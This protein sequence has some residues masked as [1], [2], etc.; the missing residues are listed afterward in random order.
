MW[1]LPCS[2]SDGGGWVTRSIEPPEQ[3]SRKP[4]RFLEDRSPKPFWLMLQ[5]IFS[6]ECEINIGAR[7]SSLKLHKKVTSMPQIRFRIVG[8]DFLERRWASYVGNVNLEDP[9]ST[10]SKLWHWK[11]YKQQNRALLYTNPNYFSVTKIHD[12]TAV[13]WD[14]RSQDSS[15]SFRRKWETC[16]F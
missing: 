6:I 7:N 9:G 12:H 1:K 15:V 11:S 3:E 8:F 4:W 16:I 2:P 10:F 13:I 5:T 14:S